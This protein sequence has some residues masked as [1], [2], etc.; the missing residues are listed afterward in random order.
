MFEEKLTCKFALMKGNI[1]ERIEPNIK[2]IENKIAKQYREKN[3]Q[4]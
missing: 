4:K 2:E 1:K 3:K